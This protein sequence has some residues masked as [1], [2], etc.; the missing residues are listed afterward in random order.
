MTVEACSSRGGDFGIEDLQSDSILCSCPEELIELIFSHLERISDR[1]HAA[2]TCRKIYRITAGGSLWNKE[3]NICAQLFCQQFPSKPLF[4][5]PIWQHNAWKAIGMY[6]ERFAALFA[7]TNSPAD[8]AAKVKSKDAFSLQ[9]FSMHRAWNRWLANKEGVLAVPGNYKFTSFGFSHFLAALEN[10]TQV[11]GLDFNCELTAEMVELLKVFLQKE[12][13]RMAAL[14]LELSQKLS[15][16]S[17]ASLLDHLQLTPK[18]EV[19]EIRGL[20]FNVLVLDHLRS[21]CDQLPNLRRLQLDLR[22]HKITEE[23]WGLIAQLFSNRSL[24]H[25]WIKGM[26][27]EGIQCIEHCLL[28]TQIPR[29]CFRSGNLTRRS[30]E[31]FVNLLTHNRSIKLL[32]LACNV[33]LDYDQVP[34]LIRIIRQRP[35]ITFGISG[36]RAI[37]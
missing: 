17:F 34:E 37:S 10:N 20:G 33:Y 31:V 14:H 36:S 4:D 6:R 30:S 1:Y 13:K 19:L 2:L 21:I 35:E 22:Y 32:D 15:A 9:E 28:T 25:L 3:H 8:M 27:D 7:D 16:H 24:E 18:L 11:T 23:E 5:P 29:I 12:G 26:N